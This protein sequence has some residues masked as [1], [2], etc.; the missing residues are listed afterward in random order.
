MRWRSGRRSSN[1][2]DRRGRRVGRPAFKGGISILVIA[3]VAM[4][5]GV[6]PLTILNIVQNVETPQTQTQQTTTQSSVNDELAEFVSVVLGDTEDTW[7]TIFNQAGKTYQEPQLVL[8]TGTVQSACGYAQAAS[9]PF[10]CPADYK[11]YIDLDFYRELKNRFQAPGDFAQAYV[12]SPEVGHHVQKLLG[13]LDKSHSLKSRASKTE[14]NQIQVRVELQADCLAGIWAHHADKARQILEQGDIQEALNAA[15][16]IGDDTL[17]KQTQGYVVPESFTH[18]SAKQR[19]H[20]FNTG[21]QSG[22]VN[23]CNTFQTA[24]L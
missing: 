21:L 24:K 17:Q 13:V 20:W 5:F 9:G 14:A 7:N 2:D 23:D 22:Q 6:D 1:V 15:S 4:F 18:G 19:M 16:R 3:V 10:Y 11:V 8:F 12:I